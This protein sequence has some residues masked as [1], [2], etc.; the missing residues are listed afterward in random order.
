MAK[1]TY[2]WNLQIT[3]TNTHMQTTKERPL[4]PDVVAAIQTIRSRQN[5]LICIQWNGLIVLIF[6]LA[7]RKSQNIT[8]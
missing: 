8:S 2:R 4:P 5:F 1:T 3:R 6:H 7:Q